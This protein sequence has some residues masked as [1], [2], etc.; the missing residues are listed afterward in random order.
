MTPLIKSV[1]RN[2]KG[3]DVFDI[4]L[5]LALVFAGTSPLLQR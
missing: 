2:R 3:L 1:A 4:L 5:L